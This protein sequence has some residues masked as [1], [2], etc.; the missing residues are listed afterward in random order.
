[1]ASYFTSLERHQVVAS[2][3]AIVWI[4]STLTAF[5]WTA[6]GRENATLWE[7]FRSD[8]GQLQYADLLVGAVALLWFNRYQTFIAKI[9]GTLNFKLAGWVFPAR[10]LALHDDLEH[11]TLAPLPS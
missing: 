4:L 6:F 2:G 3:L 11:R 5:F 8:T 10:V 1:M 9:A 7:V